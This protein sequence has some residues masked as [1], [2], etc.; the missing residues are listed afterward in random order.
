MALLV[1][2]FGVLF[3]VNAGPANAASTDAVFVTDNS[4]ISNEIP[5]VKLVGDEEEH[6]EDEEDDDEDEEEYE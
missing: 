5:G 3:G 1:F 2:A 4:D 6:D